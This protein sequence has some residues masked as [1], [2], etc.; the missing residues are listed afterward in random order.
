MRIAVLGVDLGKNVCNLVGLNA[1]GAVVLRRRAKRETVIALAAKLSP[2]IV[3]MAMG[4]LLSKARLDGQFDIASLS[5][6][7]GPLQKRC[8]FASAL[9]TCFAQ[10]H[11]PSAEGI[12]RITQMPKDLFP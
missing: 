8:N 4:F 7:R 5:G 9:T 2:C 11:R 6:P 3:G 1:S 10:C 12:V